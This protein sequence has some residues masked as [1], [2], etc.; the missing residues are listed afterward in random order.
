MLDGQRQDPVV[1]DCPHLLEL[2][3][4][5]CPGLVEL[6]EDPDHLVGALGASGRRLFGGLL[7]DDLLLVT[8]ETEVFDSALV[9]SVNRF[10]D[11]LDVPLGHCGRSISH[12]A[13]IHA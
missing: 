5:L 4:M 8:E 1:S 12:S 11:E 10:A 9:E 6:A 13:L 3:A 7:E 2:A